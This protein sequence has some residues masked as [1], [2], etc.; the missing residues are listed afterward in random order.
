MRIQCATADTKSAGSFKVSLGGG[1]LAINTSSS[2]FLSSQQSGSSDSTQPFSLLTT[3][4]ELNPFA[5]SE[6]GALSAARSPNVSINASTPLPRNREL[7]RV[8]PVT[9]ISIASGGRLLNVSSLPATDPI[10]ISVKMSSSMNGSAGERP[11]CVYWSEQEQTW[12]SKGVETVFS[13]SSSITTVT[14]RTTHLTSFSVMKSA[15][16]RVLQQSNVGLVKR[17]DVLTVSNLLDNPL[18]LILVVVINV[19]FLIL[20]FVARNLDDKARSQLLAKTMES[21]KAQPDLLSAPVE[22]EQKSQVNLSFSELVVF[23]ITRQHEIIG[24]VCHCDPFLN[25]THRTI[26]FWIAVLVQLFLSI[27]FQPI[28]ASSNSATSATFSS[29]TIWVGIYVNVISR[30]SDTVLRRML[31]KPPA[32]KAAEVSRWWVLRFDGVKINLAYL[33]AFAMG[34]FCSAFALIFCITAGSDNTMIWLKTWVACEIMD[35]VVYKPIYAFLA[36]TI[37]INVR[38]K[39]PSPFFMA[40]FELVLH[41]SMKEHLPK[42]EKPRALV[43]KDK[44]KSHLERKDLVVSDSASALSKSRALRPPDLDP[45]TLDSSSSSMALSNK[46][47]YD[48]VKRAQQKRVYSSDST[49]SSSRPRRSKKAYPPEVDSPARTRTRRSDRVDSSDE[50]NVSRSRPH[51][52]YRRKDLTIQIDLPP[53]GLVNSPSRAALPYALQHPLSP[54]KSTLVTPTAA[55]VGS[56]KN[57]AAAML[58]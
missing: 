6:P 34:V 7:T 58:K 22:A 1:N 16:V 44:F 15:P 32:D 13:N 30:A 38:D 10:T 11:L 17:R 55:A 24:I 29:A 49:V 19:S 28:V 3:S 41:V 21:Q 36:A 51:R 25:R 26:L 42:K 39:K 2:L 50:S 4:W 35:Q 56:R 54:V 52:S 48:A 5:L 8:A 12:S 57:R 37:I 9:S 45:S 47:R 14:C 43:N 40:I 33:V 20:L 18:G 27:L 31:Q 53:G 23:C 46:S